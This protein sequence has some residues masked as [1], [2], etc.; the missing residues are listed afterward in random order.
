M[1]C[2]K[3][4]R[5]RCPLRVDLSSDR[6]TSLAVV[7]RVLNV[8]STM[9]LQ[10]RIAAPWFLRNVPHDCVPQGEGFEFTRYLSTVLVAW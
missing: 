3:R 4:I 7:F 10:D 1:M 9:K 8:Y 5:R 6:Q 2:L